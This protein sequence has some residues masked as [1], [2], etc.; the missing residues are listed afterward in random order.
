MATENEQ[1]STW[2]PPKLAEEL[3]EHARKE[4]RSVSWVIRRA[5]EQYL[6]RTDAPEKAAA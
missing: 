3:R 1:L 5:V 2:L 6:A 4:D